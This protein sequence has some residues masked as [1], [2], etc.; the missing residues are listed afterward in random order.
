MNK[1]AYFFCLL[2]GL[3]LA[4]QNETQPDTNYSFGDTKIN[5]P[6]GF[7]L[8]RLLQPSN[9][10]MGTWVS[11]AE[12]P[13]KTMYACDQWG[14][15]YSFIIPEIGDTITP[16]D[17]DS[18]DLEI[19]FAHGMIWA[20]NSLYVAVNR[21]WRD[22][23]EYGSGIYRV[24]DENSDGELD[25]VNLLL[26]LEGAGEHGPH[27][28]VLSPDGSELYFI[29][30]NHT[31]VPDELLSDSRVPINW[32]EDNL[33]PTY[34]DAR[35]HA[36]DIEAP[37]GWIMKFAPDGSA[38]EL[39]SVGYR[40]PFDLAFNDNGELFAFD[41]DMEWDFGMPWYR[42]IRICH[43]TSGSE[44]GWR[45]GSGKWPTYYPDALPSVVDLGQ[46]SPTAVLYSSTLN[47]PSKYHGS[48]L[49][50]DWSFGTIYSIDLEEKGATYAGEIEQ[51]LY[52]VP[53]P[54]TDMV[55]GSDG[56]LYFATG[57]RDLS[58]ALYRLRYVG[59][60]AGN[61][62]LKPLSDDQNLRRKIES[63]HQ[64][65]PLSYVDSI[66]QYLDHEDRFV[67][68][69][70]RVALEHQPLSKWR[71]RIFE[72]GIHQRLIPAAIA[73]ARMDNQGSMLQ[74]L[75]DKLN[76]FPVANMSIDDRLDILRAYE[77]ILIR[78]GM[79]TQSGQQSLIA[80]LQEFFP[81]EDL[82]VNREAAEILI[83]LQDPKATD[84]CV[85][86]LVQHMQDSTTMDVAMI[87]DEISA[88]HEDYGSQVEAVIANMPPAEPIFYA[89]ILS[90]AKTGWTD[91][92]RKKY[93]SWFFDVLSTEGGLS[94]KAFI[95]NIRQ[96]SLANMPTAERE[97]YDE[98]SGG[99][100]PG[101][102]IANFPQPEGPGGSYDLGT[103][104]G[105]VSRGL[106]KKPL[107]FE[108][109]K[110]TYEAALCA[111]CH[112]MK[113]EGGITGPD[114]TQ[115]HTRYGRYDL[116][117]SVTSPNDEISDQYAFTLFTMKDGSKKH[118]KL[119]SETD[120]VA[121]ILPNPYSSTAKEEIQLKDVLDR[122]LS[123]I[124]P[125]PPG[126]LNRLNEEEL[127]DLF[128][129]LLSGA[130]PNHYFYGG[131]EGLDSD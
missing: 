50:A 80:R 39:V 1:R 65:M 88:R 24:T 25:Q 3:C 63:W 86:L 103:V 60:E 71:S 27:S 31:L 123:P 101:E 17:V 93:F 19:G 122:R 49:V 125:M 127:G 32:G 14:K 35:G 56:H 41:A 98:M 102:V 91:E 28:F 42:P 38:Y 21:R 52:G 128:A 131:E 36:T 111:A 62:V 130:N 97:T 58:S 55:A 107:D 76:G 23:I 118:G 43:V 13:N 95:E 61:E 116:I 78:M 113:G 48:L 115:I 69:A 121:V 100:D 46:G 87:S 66:W 22:D 92:N 12:A 94:F 126:L 68:F 112:R 54:L 70:A 89:M 40:N 83:F 33:L 8:D 18:L 120:E 73:F 59:N 11:L 74:S 77:L 15:I 16:V 79:P 81:S 9:H 84:H 124:S 6:D 7:E 119:F 4:C 5:I 85:N 64:E 51:F 72:E 104:N 106:Q 26:R 47:L 30:G 29:A 110:R 67:R 53:L 34:P 75:L 90:H 105:M 108:K 117:A 82:R 96:Q 109:G 57:G 2:L 129:Y 10:D 44:F 114:L 37:G 20:F 45:T 99:F